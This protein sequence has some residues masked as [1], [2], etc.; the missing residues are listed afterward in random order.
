LFG[1]GFGS[2]L[3]E[4]LSVD[5]GKKSKLEFTVYP[6]P[7]VSTAVVE[8]Y[9]SILA[10]H[11]MIDHSDWA[12]M[13]DKEA[14]YNLCRRSLYIERPTYM[15]LNRLIGQVVSSPTASLRFDSA[16]NVDFTEFQ[17]NMVPSAWIH[18]PICSSVPVIPSAHGTAKPRPCGSAAGGSAVVVSLGGQLETRRSGWD[19]PGN[20]F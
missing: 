6:A 20:V 7:Q 16:L 4:R 13:V 10:R 5:S 17:A 9:N 8:S 14:L 18:F 19:I 2:L 15:N 12:F 1:G 3:L 11:A